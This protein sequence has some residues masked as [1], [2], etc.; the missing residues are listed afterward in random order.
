MFQ[1]D[2]EHSHP[3]MEENKWEAEPWT[4]EG[5]QR[6]LE[7]YEES[8]KTKVQIPDLESGLFG[9][10]LQHP[11]GKPDI[12]QE[13]YLKL[14][15]YLRQKEILRQATSRNWFQE[16]IKKCSR[17]V[18]CPVCIEPL[19]SKLDFY[20]CSGNHAICGDCQRTIYKSTSNCPVCRSNEPKH[21]R[22]I[23]VKQQQLLKN[24]PSHRSVEE[25]L[26]YIRYP[27]ETV[28][29]FGEEE[30]QPFNI[31]KL[32]DLEFDLELAEF[33]RLIQEKL[34]HLSL[35]FT[36]EDREDFL[37]THMDWVIPLKHLFP[38]YETQTTSQ[39]P[40]K[41][42]ANQNLDWDDVREQVESVMW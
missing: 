34:Y 38:D 36:R 14:Q 6:E 21:Y 3:L 35:I 22:S 15:D 12:L 8:V 16:Q 1:E 27:K 39:I 13:V 20:Y 40:E 26:Y 19:S 24:N 28:N 4:L 7:S 2:L 29:V 5:I 41:T 31:H 30:H 42:I 17:E 23:L 10:L 18:D 37:E 33:L 9:C 25:L 11:F 32:N